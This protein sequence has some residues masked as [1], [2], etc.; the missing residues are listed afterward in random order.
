MEEQ[1]IVQLVELMGWGAYAFIGLA[2]LGVLM[3]ITSVVAPMT[4]TKRDDELV[5]YFQEYKELFFRLL[6]R[7]AVINRKG[8]R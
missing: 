2:V 6:A 1:I 3:V 7:F 5:T 4:K 8:N